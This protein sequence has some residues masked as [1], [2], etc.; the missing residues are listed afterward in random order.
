MK[1]FKVYL[2]FFL[3]LVY[4]NTLASKIEIKLKVDNEIITNQDIVDEANYLISMNKSLNQISKKDIYKISIQSLIKEKIKYLEV[5]KYYDVNSENEKLN[6]LVLS[7]LLSQYRVNN[8]QDLDKL[9]SNL[10][11]NMDVINT[12]I[13]IEVFWKKLIFDKYISKVSINKNKLK[14]KVTSQS[15]SN[16][17]EEFFLREIL[18]ELNNNK[19]VNDEY[20]KI[21]ETINNNTFATAASIFSISDTSLQGGEIGWIRK[22]Q[23]S[24]KLINHVINLEIGEIS[25]PIQ[26]GNKYLI[27]KLEDKRKKQIKIDIDKELEIIVQKETD[28]QLNQY[29]ANYFN[30]IKK[31]IYINEL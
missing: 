29:S 12:K 26:L 21:K 1:K 4:Q 7:N 30:K 3:C 24:E 9:F 6:E 5:I 18:F 14:E 13:K 8:K 22:S 16:Y 25:K 10:K 11:L 19:N 2:I 20:L 28:R 15:N 27:L 17:S 31:N 23:L